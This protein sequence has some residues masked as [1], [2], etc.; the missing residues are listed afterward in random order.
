MRLNPIFSSACIVISTASL[1]SGCF[2]TDMQHSITSMKDSTSDMKV[3]TA[4]MKDQIKETNK[5]VAHT[6]TTTDT[7]L[8]NGTI[9]ATFRDRDTART[10]LLGAKSMPEA[11]DAAVA[12]VY[13]M[14]FQLWDA[15]TQSV[16]ERETMYRTTLEDFFELIRGLRN[17]VGHGPDSVSPLWTDM[18]HARLYAIS[19]ALHRVNPIQQRNA[20]TYHF[21]PV[22]AVQLLEEGVKT[23]AQIDRGQI[24]DSS[25]PETSY[26]TT[27][28]RWFEDTIYILR[29]RHNYL[30]AFA[31]GLTQMSD[32]GAEPS[33]IKK[34]GNIFTGIIHKFIPSVGVTLNLDSRSVKQ[35]K[36]YDLIL[37]Y[38]LSTRKIL[39]DESYD[40]KTGKAFDPMT[41]QKIRKLYQSVKWNQQQLTAVAGESA[42]HAERREALQQLKST[43]EQIVR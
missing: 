7:L 32:K 25:I 27:V 42:A 41:D 18:D 15:N 21:T 23:Q 37:N 5:N 20:D 19:V 31:Y 29:L 13:A 36:Y 17:R 8:K 4:E 16:D 39:T 33:L 28:G 30:S 2:V 38:S 40:R 26:L 43:I 6:G 35:L 34:I 24:K 14:E 1:L 12:Y 22:S 11:L 10:Q 9:D 3:S